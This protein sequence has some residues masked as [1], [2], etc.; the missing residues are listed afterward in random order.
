MADKTS[1]LE[2]VL[3]RTRSELYRSEK[4]LMFKKIISLCIGLC[5]FDLLGA[6]LDIMNRIYSI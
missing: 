1:L 3:V 5:V 4:I 6:T 2:K